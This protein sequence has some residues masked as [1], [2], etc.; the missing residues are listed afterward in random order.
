VPGLFV[1]AAG[2]RGAGLPDVIADAQRTA[3]AV[4]AYVEGR[5]LAG[6]SA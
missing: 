1:T 2:F 3:E 4:G 5:R 6:V